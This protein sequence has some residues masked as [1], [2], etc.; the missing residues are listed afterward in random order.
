[1]KEN[2]GKIK[3]MTKYVSRVST[4]VI[5][6]AESTSLDGLTEVVLNDE[7]GGPYISLMQSGTEITLDPEEIELVYEA[8]KKLL[9][10]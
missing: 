5:E 2:Q 8:C 10:Q 7:G 9:S 4:I 1:M 3:G 6:N